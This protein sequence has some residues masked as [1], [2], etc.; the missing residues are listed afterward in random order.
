MSWAFSPYP[1]PMFLKLDRR[2]NKYYACYLSLDP[3][4]KKLFHQRTCLETSDVK[5]A[6]RIAA[7]SK[8][9]ELELASK[10]GAVTS[11]TITKIVTSEQTTVGQAIN[12]WESWVKSTNQYSE[13]SRYNALCILR[14][15]ARD[16]GVLDSP[17]SIVTALQINN[18]V[19]LHSRKRSTRIRVLSLLRV[20]FSYCR[21]TGLCLSNPAAIVRVSLDGVS[22]SQ[23]ESR[24]IRI[25]TEAECQALVRVC[26]P[27]WQAAI[28]ISYETG[29]RL[30][31]I[32]RL[33]RTCVVG[34]RLVVWM[35]K[36]DKRLEI[37]LPPAL[38]ELQRAKLLS[39]TYLFPEQL[40]VIQDP[41]RR[42][43]LSSEFRKLC[44]SVGLP[45]HT[46]HGLRHTFITRQKE[47]G[48]DIEAIAKKVGHSNTATT[49]GYIH[50]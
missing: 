26:P 16:E 14:A 18:Y 42:S 46:F 31:D 50:A 37:D 15:W 20:L 6:G 29:L 41:K 48:I 27:F 49:Q 43:Q 19:N 39:M 22:H 36:T 35:E 33:E 24:S 30:S 10:I 11:E 1:K 8:I 23:K 2:N 45:L 13:L 47:K 25:F 4:T 44:D 40:A 7:A 34:N 12:N 5:E 21:E 38:E 32:V 9:E 3:N 28:K 17:V